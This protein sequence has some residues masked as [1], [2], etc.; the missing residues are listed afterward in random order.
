[1]L[2]RAVRSQV[3]KFAS[4]SAAVFLCCPF[5]N[6]HA[7]ESAD[8][9]DEIVIVVDRTGKP[10]DIDALR[11]EEIRLET[12]RTFKLEVHKQEEELWRLKLRSGIKF[13]TS[14]IAWGYDA[15]KEAA[16]FRY[17]QANYLPIDRVR[18]A[19]VLS[20]RF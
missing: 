18:P 1:M 4:V 19:T 13:N 7:Q 16:R 14:R 8:T 11:L 6:A 15:Q 17:S 9:I 10:V 20:I 2:N 5:L 12:I 3:R